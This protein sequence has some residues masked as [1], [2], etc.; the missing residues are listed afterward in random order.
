[1]AY[2]Y[3]ADRECLI[4]AGASTQTSRPAYP[5]S[6]TTSAG[7]NQ[8]FGSDQPGGLGLPVVATPNQSLTRE[9][10]DC[11]EHELHEMDETIA[12]LE[13]R[14]HPTLSPLSQAK[15][16]H[17][18]GV[19]TPPLDSVSPLT[20]TVHQAIDVVRMLRAR[21]LAVIARVEL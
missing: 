21:L 5:S 20:A 13:A 14:L 17:P 12:A 2:R 4:G 19:P 6:G 1:M 16:L 10:L 11:L 18:S 9:A 8:P 15:D 7:F 3:D